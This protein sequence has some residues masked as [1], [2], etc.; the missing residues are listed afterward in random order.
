MRPLTRAVLEQ[1]RYNGD[2]IKRLQYY[3]STRIT[4]EN[5]IG[6]QKLEISPQG[7]GLLMENYETDRIIIV[8][9]AGGILVRAGEDRT[10]RLI[11]DV[12]FEDDTD[13]VLSFRENHA[14]RYFYLIDRESYGERL[15]RYGDGLY[16][17]RAHGN[18][19]HL[20]IQFAE[21]TETWP[22]NR[23]VRGRLLYR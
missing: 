9:E 21:I 20:L 14:D 8:K 15:V 4:L 6:T 17:L 2:D 18:K 5:E 12:S 22:T 10:G 13:A 11:L 7:E 3:I 16:S 23:E 19:P 1:L